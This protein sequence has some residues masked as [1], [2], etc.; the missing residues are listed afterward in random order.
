MSFGLRFLEMLVAGESRV[1]FD[2][3][4]R[5]AIAGEDDP[6][7]QATLR[8]EYELALQIRDQMANQRNREVVMTRLNDIA[9]GLG[10]IRDFDQVLDEIVLRARQLLHADMTYLALND[11]AGETSC[12]KAAYGAH[13]DRLHGLAVPLGT[14]LLGLVAEGGE[15]HTTADYR[16]DMRFRHEARVD[17]AVTAENIRAILGVPLRVGGRVIGVLLAAH[18]RVRRFPPAEKALLVHF[19]EHAAIAIEN[20]RLF[21]ESSNALSALGAANAELRVRQDETERS[22]LAYDR[23]TDVLL[24]QGDVDQV[25]IVVTSVLG[26]SLGVFSDDG[27]IEGE[28]GGLDDAA[29]DAAVAARGRCVHVAPDGWVVHATTADDHAATLLLRR[30]APL[31]V[32]EQRTLE[33][34]ASVTALIL[35][36]RSVEIDAEWKVRRELLTDLIGK[37]DVDP[38]KL[39]ERARRQGVSLDADLSIAVARP[40]SGRAQE[41]QTGRVAAVLASDL[42]GLATVHRGSVVVLAPTSPHELGERV[43]ARLVGATVGVARCGPGPAGIPQGWT[44]AEQT[45]VA[46]LRLGRVGEISDSVGLGLARLLLGHNGSAELDDYIGR[47]L[48][49]LIEHDERR[50]TELIDTLTNWFATGGSVRETADRMHVHPNTVNQ[51]FDRI[52][53]LVGQSWRDP[54]RRIDLQVALRLRQLQGPGN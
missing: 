22:S 29:R 6:D 26:G 20:A 23:L 13:T 44:D 28:P 25:A 4:L 35:L 18:R 48:G 53:K 31:D 34:A 46:L 2:T 24:S 8:R 38:V 43:A 45:L 5:D 15:P 27:L 19:A 9:T 50:G 3:A 7:G 36:F 32:G 11:E 49:P 12:I 30:D 21:E 1:D 40:V 10:E 51:R 39:R 33:R 17:A 54:E 14:G 52:A 41:S 47:T 16:Y 42:K 37:S